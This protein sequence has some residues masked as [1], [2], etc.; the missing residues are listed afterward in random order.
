MLNEHLMLLMVIR[1]LDSPSLAY[2]LSMCLKL[3]MFFG[4]VGDYGS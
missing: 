4:C 2:H 1:K 3:G